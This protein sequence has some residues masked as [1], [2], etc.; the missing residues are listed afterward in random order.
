MPN[1]ATVEDALAFAIGRASAA[2]QW[3]VVDRPERKAWHDASARPR[4]L[5]LVSAGPRAVRR[6]SST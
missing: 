2:G 4:F 1:P 5:P 3:A 6:T